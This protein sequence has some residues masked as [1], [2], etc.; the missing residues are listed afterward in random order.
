MRRGRTVELTYGGL[1]GSD[2]SRVLRHSSLSSSAPY[3]LHLVHVT[4]T[5]AA[6]STRLGLIQPAD[7]LQP[8]A[9]S[10][11]V[12]DYRQESKTTYLTR[13]PFAHIW[14]SV[15]S[16]CTCHRSCAGLSAASAI[17]QTRAPAAASPHPPREQCSRMALTPLG[18]PLARGLLCSLL[19]GV[20]PDS[21]PAD[22]RPPP[23]QRARSGANS[24]RPARGRPD[25][26]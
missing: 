6:A 15:S 19:F 23:P 1:A 12:T 7:R 16:L 24:G 8:R 17:I 3:V 10:L 2:L 14:R 5:A 18:R 21:L 26:G 20:C 11:P 9:A 13:R 4:R 25:V 22:R